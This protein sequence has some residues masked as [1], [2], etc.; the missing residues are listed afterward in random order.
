MDEDESGIEASSEL[1]EIGDLQTANT[2]KLLLDENHQVIGTVEEIQVKSSDVDS[3]AEC[4]E[5]TCA[6]EDNGSGEISFNEVISSSQ[7]STHS[8]GSAEEDNGSFNPIADHII[9]KVM[10]YLPVTSLLDLSLI[11]KRFNTILNDNPNRF[12]LTLCLDFDGVD[13]DENHDEDEDEFPEVFVRCYRVVKVVHLT[14][15]TS[16]DRIEKFINLFK[17][18][19]AHIHDIH[20]TDCDLTFEFFSRLITIMPNIVSLQLEET[21]LNPGAN[22]VEW[23]ALTSL[24]KVY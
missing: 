3:S 23:P 6:E 19:G 16:E 20:F 4:L 2:L 5:M 15:P 11:S 14:T 18:F 24:K 13:E 10:D 21:D 22:D 7:I 17:S 9:M 12:P 8:Q 1:A